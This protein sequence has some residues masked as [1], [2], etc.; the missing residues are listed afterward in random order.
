[1]YYDDGDSRVQADALTPE[2][3]KTFEVALEQ[4]LARG[5]WATASAFMYEI[6]NVISDVTISPGVTQFQNG[7]SVKAKGFEF[8]LD[9]KWEN[10][11]QTRFSYCFVDTDDKQT[12][13][14]LVNSPKQMIK[15][16]LTVPVIKKKLF[17]GIETQYFDKRK[18]LLGRASDYFILTNLTLTYK[19]V[20]KGLDVS[21]GIYN[22]FDDEYGTPG[23]SEHAQD[24]IR[25]DGRS[26]RLKLTYRF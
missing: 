7:K 4:N 3:I 13:S 16:N 19:E 6:E 18:T 15:A 5:L 21:F 11:W 12:N 10:D 22:L 23:F 24:T 17:A 26:Y 14:H 20:A 2:T 1:M 9:G 8:E 25:Q